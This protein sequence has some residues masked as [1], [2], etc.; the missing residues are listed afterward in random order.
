MSTYSL[1]MCVCVC[2]M[3]DFGKSD[4]MTKIRGVKMDKSDNGFKSK[5]SFKQGGIKYYF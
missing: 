5:I 2:E 3:I 1:Y 4:K